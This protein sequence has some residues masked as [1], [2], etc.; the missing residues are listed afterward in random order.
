MQRAGLWLAAL[1]LATL[2]QATNGPTEGARFSTEQIEAGRNQFHRTCAQ[3]HGRNMVNAG[4]TVFDLRKF[5][6]DQPDR[7]QNSVTNG[8]G[9]MPSFKEALTAEQIG[10]LWAYVGTRGG[11]EP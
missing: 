7:F 6:L 9:N 5:P 11:K 2:A 1:P 8:K 3:C 4:T 10:I